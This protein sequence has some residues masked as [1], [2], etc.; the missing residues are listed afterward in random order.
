MKESQSIILSESSE[1]QKYI[2]S[3]I[4]FIWSLKTEKNLVTLQNK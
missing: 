1:P 3:M 4:Q 2:Y